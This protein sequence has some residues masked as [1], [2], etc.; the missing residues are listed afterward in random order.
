M[1]ID[2]INKVVQESL[3]EAMAFF[4]VKL[5]PPEIIATKTGNEWAAMISSHQDI[6]VI[7]ASDK[8]RVTKI[9]SMRIIGAA[10]QWVVAD[11]GYV[12][13]THVGHMDPIL[14][15]RGETRHFCIDPP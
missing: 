7:M 2:C 6:A 10:D 9:E 15:I 3:S 14:R 4:W 1:I 5:Q 11:G 12:F 13:P 8:V